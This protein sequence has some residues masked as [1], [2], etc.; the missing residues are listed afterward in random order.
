MSMLLS[1]H[2]LPQGQQLVEIARVVF[3][4]ATI[5]VLDEPTSALS[6]PGNTQ[7]QSL[8]TVMP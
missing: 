3:S 6:T 1:L 8:A 5:L 7:T 2:R 4:G